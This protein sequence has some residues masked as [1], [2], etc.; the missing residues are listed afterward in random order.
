MVKIYIPVKFGFSILV[1]NVVAGV[2]A[3]ADVE[4]VWVFKVS[5]QKAQKARKKI[6]HIIFLQHILLLYFLLIKTA[7]VG[8]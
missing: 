1:Q 4:T 3:F 5:E 7:V 6:F 2:K 8:N